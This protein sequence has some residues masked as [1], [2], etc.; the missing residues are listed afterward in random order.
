MSDERSPTDES[1]DFPSCPACGSS[2]VERTPAAQSQYHCLDCGHEYDE[3][4]RGVIIQ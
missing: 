1:E 2:N 3:G 4:G